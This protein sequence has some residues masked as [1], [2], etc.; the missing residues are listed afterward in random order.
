MRVKDIEKYRY[1]KEKNKDEYSK[2]VFDYAERW[3]EL[4][5]KEIAKGKEIKDIYDSCSEEANLT[6][7]TGAMN[8]SA[9]AVLIKCWVHGEELEKALL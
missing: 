4:M 7:I 5:E 9:A 3:A 2:E 8:F 6:G 1:W